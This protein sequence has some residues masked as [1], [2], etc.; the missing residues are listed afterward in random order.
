MEREMKRR[1]GLRLLER[2]KEELKRGL[3]VE[4]RMSLGRISSER[5]D[6]EKRKKRAQGMMDAHLNLARAHTAGDPNP[7]RRWLHHTR[8]A[9][10]RP[11]RKRSSLC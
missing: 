10:A 7:R 5:R 3:R 8:V 11:P 2:Q 1:E 6:V 9:R 4:S